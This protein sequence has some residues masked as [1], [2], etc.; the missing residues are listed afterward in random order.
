[1]FVATLSGSVSTGVVN[2]LC[3]P[4]PSQQRRS[5]AAAVWRQREGLDKG[6]LQVTEPKLLRMLCL[7]LLLLLLL[8]PCC[9]CCCCAAVVAVCASSFCVCCFVYPSQLAD[10]MPTSSHFYIAG[11][12]SPQGL[13]V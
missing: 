12:G 1:M 10:G 6:Q 9:C 5:I 2:N 7:C 3:P 13:A 8:L 11:P 4:H